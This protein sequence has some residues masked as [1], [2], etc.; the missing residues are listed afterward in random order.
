M[1]VVER[2]EDFQKAFHR[3]KTQ[4]KDEIRKLSKSASRSTKEVTI[5]RW[6]IAEDNRYKA[7]WNVVIMLIVTFVSIVTPVRLCFNDEDS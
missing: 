4:L 3:K 6:L 7:I 5:S 2:R 1:D